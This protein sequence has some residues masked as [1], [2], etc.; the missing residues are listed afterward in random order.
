[1]LDL[2]YACFKMILFLFL[3]VHVSFSWESLSKFILL[4]RM[5]LKFALLQRTLI[6]KSFGTWL[7][8]SRIFWRPNHCYDVLVF[9]LKKGCTFVTFSMQNL[10]YWWNNTLSYSEKIVSHLNYKYIYILMALV[11][12][13]IILGFAMTPCNLSEIE[14]V[15]EYYF[16]H[17]ILH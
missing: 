16:L 1:M 4:Q 8:F 6:N 14:D 10:V 15:C 5:N 17:R 2:I 7:G 9:E 12:T 11:A 13:F 3:F